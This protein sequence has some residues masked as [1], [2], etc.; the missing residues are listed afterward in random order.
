MWQSP[1]NYMLICRYGRHRTMQEFLDVIAKIQQTINVHEVAL[2]KNE[3]MTRYALIDPLL[4]ELDWDLSN[5]SEV[6]PED[7]TGPGGKTD[8]TLGHKAMIVEAKKLDENL[9]KYTDKLID[10]VR[11]RNV[12]YGVLTNGRKWRMYD[13]NATTKSPE[14]E[15]DVTDS[16]GMVISKAIRLHRVVVLGN[17]P[18][19]TITPIKKIDEMYEMLHP[20]TRPPIRH[21]P[22]I[23]LENVTYKKGS[24][25]PKILIHRDGSQKALESWVDLLGSVAEWL[26]NNG[27]LTAQHCPI[28]I[29]PRNYLLHV[30][31]KHPTGKLFSTYRE[32]GKLYV[33]TNVGPSNI[34]RYANKLVM[35]AGLMQSD[36]K[37][38]FQPTK[39]PS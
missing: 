11:G 26:I 16:E 5:P 18:R 21:V 39:P 13:A 32:I 23:V 30:E 24:S 4:R 29:G 37:V 14:A 38:D 35:T 8:Y 25:H 19:H 31:P 7:N 15:F 28:R 17:M 9:D 10:Y 12:R 6:V 20:E 36:F 2:S 22:G 33:F 34:I 1:D 27:H 3:T